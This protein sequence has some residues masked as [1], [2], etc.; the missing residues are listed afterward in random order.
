MSER[1]GPPAARH[2]RPAAAGRPADRDVSSPARSPDTAARLPPGSTTTYMIPYYELVVG[3]RNFRLPVCGSDITAAFTVFR[4]ASQHL[5]KKPGKYELILLVTLKAFITADAVTGQRPLSRSLRLRRASSAAGSH[6]T[7]LRLCVSAHMH[8]LSSL[9]C[10]Y[11]SL[12]TARVSWPLASA[13]RL[14]HAQLLR[15]A[16]AESRVPTSPGHMR[17]ASVL[18]AGLGP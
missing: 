7:R 4:T 1:H 3:I 16:Y 9:I 15:A 18:Q 2:A 11:L 14:L 17:L 8:A 13:L 10:L 12:C 5:T 6:A